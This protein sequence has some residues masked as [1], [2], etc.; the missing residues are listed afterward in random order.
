MYVNKRNICVN[1][2]NDGK[3][4]ETASLSEIHFSKEISLSR[5]PRKES[6]IR[7]NSLKLSY[8]RENVLGLLLL[9]GRNAVD[10]NE[11]KMVRYVLTE[12]KE[13]KETATAAFAPATI[14]S[15]ST[16][17]TCDFH[18]RGTISGTYRSKVV[19]FRARANKRDR[20][21]IVS[22]LTTVAWLLKR[23]LHCWCAISR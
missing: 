20:S 8:A 6:K 11:N 12:R 3:K 9:I 14:T 10:L 18:R 2:R 4:K 21:Q 22:L 15:V 16:K 17:I 13:E 7:D 5:D 23:T 19:I 1:K